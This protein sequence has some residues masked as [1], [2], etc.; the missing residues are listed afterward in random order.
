[1]LFGLVHIY[2]FNTSWDT[3]KKKVIKKIYALNILFHARGTWNLEVG[4]GQ[5]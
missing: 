2:I 5:A 1:M 3:Q 4:N